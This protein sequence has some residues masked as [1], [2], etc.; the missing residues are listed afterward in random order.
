MPQGL[1]V[2]GWDVKKRNKSLQVTG[3]LCTSFYGGKIIFED[4]CLHSMME[5]LLWG[6]SCLIQLLNTA[7]AQ[8]KNKIN[9][10]LDLL[11][12]EGADFQ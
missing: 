1:C 9:P 4:I 3:V 7:C 12:L 8:N 10:L 11:V 6:I 5:K 2:C